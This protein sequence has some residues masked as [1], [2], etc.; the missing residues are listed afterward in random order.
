MIVAGVNDTQSSVL[1]PQSSQGRVLFVNRYFPPDHSATSQMVGDLA[2]FLAGRGH[3]VVAI[4]SRQRYDDASARLA[5]RER[6]HGVDVVRVATTRF[7][8][9]FL[10]GRA[11]DYATFYLSAFFAL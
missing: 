9:G 3:D 10:P 11:L 2:F 4:T 7:G 5:P 8:R 1:S 6:L